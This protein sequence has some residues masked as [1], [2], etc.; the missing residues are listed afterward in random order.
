M[1]S[2]TGGAWCL[3]LIGI[4]IVI[5]GAEHLV[6]WWLVF[7]QPPPPRHFKAVRKIDL[8]QLTSWKLVVCGIC[9]CSTRPRTSPEGSCHEQPPW[10]CEFEAPG[11]SSDPVVVTRSVH[12]TAALS[13]AHLWFLRQA[14]FGESWLA[15]LWM[16]VE[17]AWANTQ[18]F[19]SLLLPPKASHPLPPVPWTTA[20]CCRRLERGTPAPGDAEMRLLYQG[21][22]GHRDQPPLSGYTGDSG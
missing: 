22:K 8:W 7:L 18:G 13:H 3:V 21:P 16:G 9:F 15:G 5:R 1:V 4:P 20:P 10:P 2:L 6:L 19:V 11:S 17:C 14:A 12:K